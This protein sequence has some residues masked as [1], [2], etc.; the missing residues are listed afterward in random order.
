MRP[1]S[2]F[3]ASW[4]LTA[5][6]FWAPQAQ[7]DH[8]QVLASIYPLYDF[9]R[10]VGGPEADVKLLLPP[11][12]SPHTWEPKPSDIVRL[13]QADLFLYVGSVMEPWAEKLLTAAAEKKEIHVMG[14]L[15]ALGIGNGEKPH[16]PGTARGMDHDHAADPH[17]WLDFSLAARS[18]RAMGERM[19]ALYPAGAQGF[20][21]RAEAYANRL[22]ALDERFSAG[23]SRCRTRVFVTGGHSSFGYLAERYGLTQVPLYGISPD[24]EPTPAWL[25]SV[26]RKG[27]EESLNVIFF[28]EMVSPRLAE[29]LALEIGAR[30]LL[31]TPA[32]NITSLRQAEGTDFIRIMEENLAALREGLSCE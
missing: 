15:R 22:L 27:R 18:V 13:S 26:V 31:L 32:G 28:E 20:V 29:V 12:A 19:A 21:G 25:A 1:F 14:M 23:L 10:E 16:E 4:F 3:I 2:P 30:T 9:A 5:A 11:G 8:L 7:A 24:S 6:V 17:F